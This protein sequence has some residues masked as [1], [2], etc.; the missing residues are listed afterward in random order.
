MTDEFELSE[1]NFNKETKRLYSIF[2]EKLNDIDYLLNHKE[3]YL[4]DFI[5]RI[6]NQIDIQRESLIQQIHKISHHMI[7]KLDKYQNECMRINL[8]SNLD[9]K[10]Y[11]LL[12]QKEN[13]KSIIATNPYNKQNF[14]NGLEKFEY[15]VRKSE[16]FKSEIQSDYKMNK[17]CFF[18]AVHFENENNLFGSLYLNDLE[19]PLKNQN[20]IELR[21]FNDEINCE[22]DDKLEIIELIDNNRVAIG[23]RNGNIKI[24]NLNSTECV[25]VIEAF[26]NSPINILNYL[27]EDK[28][29][30]C[31]NLNSNIKIWDLKTNNLII[32]LN[33][34]SNLIKDLCLSDE[35][36]IS[37]SL[38]KKI[39][40]WD[41]INFR[42][43]N[44]LNT[45][46]KFN[47]KIAIN[48]LG[49]LITCNDE[50][51]MKKWNL[52]TNVCEKM[53]EDD[54]YDFELI[55]V[56]K[57]YIISY[58]HGDLIVFWDSN[59]FNRIKSICIGFYSYRFKHISLHSDNIL[60]SGYTFKPDDQSS[61]YVNWELNFFDIRNRRKIFRLFQPGK[62]VSYKKMPNG[63]LI[64]LIED[65]IIKDFDPNVLRKNKICIYDIN[66][67]N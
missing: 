54:Y 61:S 57:D 49:K 14:Q 44:T 1:E 15:A 37:V 64:C 5:S 50:G 56:S 23:C 31:S 29:I 42:C 30:T 19:K 67:N 25:A 35:K 6:K 34:H 41:T 16:N 39:K 3:S 62:L 22:S 13:L 38:D 2:E 46:F 47:I 48:T 55:Q 43:L 4:D 10:R 8:K 33:E 51:L 40:I 18:E 65:K 21:S 11:G 52:E 59:S 28:L 20:A 9:Q 17:V 63:N 53:F 24:F 58:G 45:Q 32:S 60:I 7:T 36:I 27:S 12:V 66:D 26:Q